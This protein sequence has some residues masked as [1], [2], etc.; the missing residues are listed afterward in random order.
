MTI[1]NLRKQLKK[2]FNDYV[3]MHKAKDGFNLTVFD[4]KEKEV[5]DFVI[6]N[7]GVVFEKESGINWCDRHWVWYYVEV[8]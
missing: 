3:S 8:K 5:L 6:E 2:L 1:E 7:G 4:N